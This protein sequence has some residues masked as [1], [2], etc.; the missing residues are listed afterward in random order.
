MYDDLYSI[1]PFDTAAGDP[2]A[3]LV[4][5]GYA[6]VEDE[7]GFHL[8]SIRP[9]EAGTTLTFDQLPRFP[10]SIDHGRDFDGDTWE[11]LGCTESYVEVDLTG[12]HQ[13]NMYGFDFDGDLVTDI[14]FRQY[15]VNDD[16]EPDVVGV[17]YDQDG[18]I[19]EYLPHPLT[20]DIHD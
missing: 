10:G 8:V 20:T 7:S 15:D 6:P 16:G 4:P 12:D 11:T 18:Y 9:E 14:A 13:P 19:D 1:N 5:P 17:D 2:S 3:H